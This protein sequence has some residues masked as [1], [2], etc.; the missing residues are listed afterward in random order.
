MVSPRSLAAARKANAVGRKALNRSKGH[1]DEPP[2]SRQIPRAYR[3]TLATCP[4]ARR[5]RVAC[6]GGMRLGTLFQ[7]SFSSNAVGLPPSPTQAVGSVE[8][9]GDPGSVV[10][11]GPV[12]NSNESWV[13]ITR[14][15]VA[16]NQA[17]IST[18]LGKFS[19]TIPTARTASSVRSS[20]RRAADSRRSSSTPA[21]SA[22]RRRP[23]S[24]ISISCRT[25]RCASTT[26]L[27]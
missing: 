21:R 19:K 7:S 12:P 4:T 13:K 1:D 14:A 22:G 5:W 2:S 3:S 11:V 6:A 10:I 25:A 16:N 24:C 27:A 20:F 26:I 9:S 15:S 17:G 8:V 18:F 23:V